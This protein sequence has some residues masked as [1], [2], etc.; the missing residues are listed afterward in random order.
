MSVQTDSQWKVRS[1]VDVLINCGIDSIVDR[2]SL[3]HTRIQSKK[4]QLRHY[5]RCQG[6]TLLSAPSST[7]A[8]S[9]CFSTFTAQLWGLGMNSKSQSIPS[10]LGQNWEEDDEPIRSRVLQEKARTL[11]QVDLRELQQQ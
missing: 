4:Q 6:K 2:K 5:H 1:S 3:V 8:T 11:S 10:H 9:P 7:P